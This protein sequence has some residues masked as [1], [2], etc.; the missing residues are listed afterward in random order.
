MSMSKYP[1]YDNINFSYLGDN[2]YLE[3]L[4]VTKKT[5]K[6]NVSSTNTNNTTNT[7]N[8][9]AINFSI[10][11]LDNSNNVEKDYNIWDFFGLSNLT[12]SQNECL[13]DCT[14]KITKCLIKCD[15][16]NHKYEKCKY[17]CV[18]NS[19][20]CLKSCSLN[21]EQVSNNKINILNNNIT[22]NA[23][24]INNNNKVL[25]NTIINNDV[26][27]RNNNTHDPEGMYLINSTYANYTPLSKND[28]VEI[29]LEPSLI[30]KIIKRK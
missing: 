10:K 28:T 16:N 18:D 1:L 22:D 12:K 15:G 5:P 4:Y 24:P 7:K 17:K 6:K 23:A 13:F 21:N 27:F 30:Y 2:G 14:K 29:D 26:L 3:N 9:T 20:D 8:D 19:L 25:D 11:Q